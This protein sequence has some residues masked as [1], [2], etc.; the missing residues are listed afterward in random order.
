MLGAAGIV[1]GAFL[2]RRLAILIVFVAMV[3]SD[4]LIGFHSLAWV[5]YLCLALNCLLANR[6]KPSSPL[7]SFAGLGM[8][9]ASLFFF[10]TN[11]AV[12]AFSDM[13][14]RTWEGLQVCFLAALPFF[15][16][17]LLSDVLF[18]VILI[19][20]ARLGVGRVSVVKESR[21]F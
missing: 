18:T 2:N 9:T 12:W 21:A 19:S 4:A 14:P 1:A 16:N 13:Y 7:V 15:P 20:A 11:L 17:T 3:L 8:V 5:V 6:L 10:I